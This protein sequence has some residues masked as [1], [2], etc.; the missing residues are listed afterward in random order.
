HRLLLNLLD[1]AL[2][3]S[4]PGSTVRLVVEEA[5]GGCRIAVHDAGPPI[6]PDAAERIFERFYR[7]DKARSRAV[8]STT[9]G[10]GLG[11]SIARWVAEAHGGSLR[12]ARSGAGGNLF[13]LFLPAAHPGAADPA[14]HAPAARTPARDDVQEMQET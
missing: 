1:N 2:K 9:G 10:A 6:P 12:L 3:Y 14:P 13:E 4:P 8:E 11:L 5:P 7:V